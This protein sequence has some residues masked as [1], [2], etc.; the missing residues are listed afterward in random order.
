MCL[1]LPR[2]RYIEDDAI[3]VVEQKNKA[4]PPVL[5]FLGSSGITSSQLSGRHFKTLT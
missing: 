3:V 2:H 4:A 5:L 1:R